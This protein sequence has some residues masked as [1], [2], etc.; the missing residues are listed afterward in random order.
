MEY[1]RISSLH[2]FRKSSLKRANI[3]EDIAFGMVH[4]ARSD[5]KICLGTLFLFHV[6]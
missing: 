6:S 4:Y 2:R 5:Y 3:K 1:S